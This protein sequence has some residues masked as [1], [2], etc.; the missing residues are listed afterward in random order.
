MGWDVTDRNVTRV[1]DRN[2]AATMSPSFERCGVGIAVNE[3][4]FANPISRRLAICESPGLAQIWLDPRGRET[5]I[6][7]T[8][9]MVDP[10][11]YEIEPGTTLYRFASYLDGVEGAMR[12][13]WWIERQQLDHLIRYGEINGKTLGYAVR[14]LCCV[15]PEWGGAL[16]FVIR[17]KATRLLAAWRGLAN[18]AV[19]PSKRLNGMSPVG[20]STTVI[21]TRND[22]AAL[23]VPQLFIPGTRGDGATGAMFSFEGQWQ[24][25]GATD[26]ILGSG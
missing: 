25:E 17:V 21:A 14:I 20:V 11:R 26:W 6:I 18:T 5:R 4:D 7:A 13:G 24:T 2:V 12:G 10:V 8:G 3:Q 15:P 23:R 22:I 16:N 9:G 1:S 19:A